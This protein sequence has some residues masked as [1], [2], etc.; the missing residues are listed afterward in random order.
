VSDDRYQALKGNTFANLRW[1]TPLREYKEING[2]KVASN[3]E[4]IWHM[5]K[6]EFV[7]AQ[8]HLIQLTYNV[9]RFSA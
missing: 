6:S 5:P 7:Y 4:A 3:G 2:H 9:K 1:S 8:F